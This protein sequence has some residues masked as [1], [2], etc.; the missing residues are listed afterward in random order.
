M[1]FPCLGTV[2]LAHSDATF[3]FPE[4]RRGALPGVVSVAARQRLSRAACERL[5]CTGDVIDAPTAQRL[6]LV[7]VVGGWAEL[8]TEVARLERHFLSSAE[9]LVHAPGAEPSSAPAA[10]PAPFEVGSNSQVARLSV[11]AE[12]ATRLAGDALRLLAQLSA[13]LRVLVLSV[14]ASDGQEGEGGEGWEGGGS[15]AAPCAETGARIEAAMAQLTDAGVAIVAC[16]RGHVR[17]PPLLRACLAS[18]YRVVEAGSFF[19]CD[20]KDA[21]S[22]SAAFRAPP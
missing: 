1:A 10:T 19:C 20:S 9:R 15:S 18:H 11:T 16:V 7:D 8:E 22:R 4:I 5:F 3:G 21:P 2:V 13:S 14:E 17:A 6:G 12:S